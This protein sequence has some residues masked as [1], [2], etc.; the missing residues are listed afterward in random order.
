[1]QR[2]DLR[3]PARLAPLEREHACVRALRCNAFG[4]A[5]IS[6]PKTGQKNR[7]NLKDG[8]PNSERFAPFTAEPRTRKAGFPNLERFVAV[9]SRTAN[10]KAYKLA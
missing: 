3:E 1:M 8:F 5:A 10:S 7:R 2:G 9:Y 4:E 6:R